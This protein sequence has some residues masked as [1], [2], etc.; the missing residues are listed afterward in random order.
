[1]INFNSAL[2]LMVISIFLASA[3]VLTGPGPVAAVFIQIY[4]ALAVASASLIAAGFSLINGDKVACNVFMGIALAS[5]GFIFASLPGGSIVFA[6]TIALMFGVGSSGL[7]YLL[8]GK[9]CN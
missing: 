2:I 1:M 5:F 6:P 7:G 8:T 3:A 4:A 9:V